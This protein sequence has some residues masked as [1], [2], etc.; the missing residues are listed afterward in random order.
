[1]LS[2]FYSGGFSGTSFVWENCLNRPGDKP[3]RSIGKAA[4]SV[5]P[6]LTA[7]H[8][9]S[10]QKTFLQVPSSKKVANRQ[11]SHFA[12]LRCAPFL[13]RLFAFTS[14]LA[15][16]SVRQRHTQESMQAQSGQSLHASASLRYAVAF[17]FVS[18]FFP[19]AGKFW[20]EGLNTFIR[21]TYF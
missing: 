13:R 7:I 9:F 1:M 19:H 4:T 16:S 21:I 6:P 17:R 10:T 15:C 2:W 11:L 20:L 12:S 8:L 5:L 3:L 18:C 14:K